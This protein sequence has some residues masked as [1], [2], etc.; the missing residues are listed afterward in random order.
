MNHL[1]FDFRVWV[2]VISS[3]VSTVT[4]F[5]CSCFLVDLGDFFL[6]KC[7]MVLKL[8]GL[9]IMHV[10]LQTEFVLDFGSYVERDGAELRL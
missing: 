3:S 8:Q 7:Q 6:I 10:F 2:L 5:F 9:W 4:F 1:Y